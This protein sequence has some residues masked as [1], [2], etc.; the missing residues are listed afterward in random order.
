MKLK[1]LILALVIVLTSCGQ[2]SSSRHHKK[3]RTSSDIKIS[4]LNLKTKEIQMRF[5][6]R[7]Y[8]EKTLESINCEIEF[9]K[10]STFNISQ[11][12]AIELGAFSTEIL[13][14]HAPD[15]NQDS[16]L[17]NLSAIDYDINCEMIYNKGSE[18][19][20]ETSVLHLVPSEKFIYR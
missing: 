19:V 12:Q 15:I 5:E 13:K 14:F 7:S 4:F 16:S 8:V 9:N 20:V 11:S 17:T 3:Q 10:Q 18:Y 1:L 6:Y 2:S